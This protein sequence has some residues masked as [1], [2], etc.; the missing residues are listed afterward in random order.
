MFWLAIAIG[1]ESKEARDLCDDAW[2][3]MKD[4]NEVRAKQL[5]DVFIMKQDDSIRD[6]VIGNRSEI[7]NL[8]A[9]YVHRLSIEDAA[10]IYVEFLRYIQFD[11]E[12][13]KCL[14]VPQNDSNGAEWT[15][16]HFAR[17]IEHQDTCQ[18]TWNAMTAEQMI[19]NVI[20]ADMV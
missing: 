15:M 1:D 18:S 20:N 10:Q 13:F 2:E 5:M 19:F 14:P 9:E 3:P 11:G 8:F 4:D 16:F 6:R 12:R 7:F 17:Y